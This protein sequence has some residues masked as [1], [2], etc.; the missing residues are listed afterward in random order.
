MGEFPVLGFGAHMLRC[1]LLFDNL[2]L[3]AV[4]LAV[5][6]G[7]G[8]YS[9][10]FSLVEPWFAPSVALAVFVMLVSL[11]GL[12]GVCGNVRC[13]LFLY[14][15]ITFLV[16]LALLVVSSYALANNNDGARFVTTAFDNA[17]AEVRRRLQFIFSCCGLEKF[18]DEY[19]VDP[20]PL[21]ASTR[22]MDPLLEEFNHYATQVA[23][24]GLIVWGALWIIAAMTL[25]LAYLIKHSRHNHH[26]HAEEY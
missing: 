21:N 8:Y 11:I 4:S 1:F 26:R 16:G 23:I 5:I 14:V 2:V 10:V 22:C 3:F 13:L 17:P 6:I 15:T 20:C 9:H 25:H 18:R 7:V 24:L 12:F 19:A